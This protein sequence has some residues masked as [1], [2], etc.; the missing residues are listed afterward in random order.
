M[1]VSVETFE[2]YSDFSIFAIAAR[3]VGYTFGDLS[4]FKQRGINRSVKGVVWSP[5]IEGSECHNTE[6]EC[7]ALLCFTLVVACLSSAMAFLEL[8]YSFSFLK[9]K[10]TTLFCLDVGKGSALGEVAVNGIQRMDQY[11][12]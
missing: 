1:S 6:G 11:N 10:N 4:C 3:S 9:I 12:F 7:F 5:L 8:L 2:Q